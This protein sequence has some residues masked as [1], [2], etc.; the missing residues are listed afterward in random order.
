MSSA[1]LASRH[2]VPASEVVTALR[3]IE[4]GVVVP[5]PF[6]A[7]YDAAGRTSQ[8]RL[9]H[10][11]ANDRQGHRQGDLTLDTVLRDIADLRIAVRHAFIEAS[12]EYQL[13]IELSDNGLRDCAKCVRELESRAAQHPYNKML[14]KIDTAYD[15]AVRATRA[16]VKP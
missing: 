5:G 4:N 12:P 16:G 13:L 1:A 8:S 6:A 14:T 7:N 11:P 2:S 3:R 9:A 15:S 10:D